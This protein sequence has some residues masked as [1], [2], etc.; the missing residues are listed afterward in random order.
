MPTE[1]STGAATHPDGDRETT[2]VELQLALGSVRIVAVREPSEFDGELG[3]L[4]GAELVLL[5][6]LPDATPPLGPRPAAR[7]GVP[8]GQ[9]FWAGR[10]PVGVPGLAARAEPSRRNALTQRG[11]VPR[12]AGAAVGAQ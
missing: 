7:R 6:A 4:P 1:P 11:R 5:G 2:P 12:R 9:A 10:R 3:H 8:L